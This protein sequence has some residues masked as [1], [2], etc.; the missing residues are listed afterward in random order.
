MREGG[1]WAGA[2]P[3]RAGVEDSHGVNVIPGGGLKD[4]STDRIN[5]ALFSG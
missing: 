3:S 4:S 1:G 5:K 2:A